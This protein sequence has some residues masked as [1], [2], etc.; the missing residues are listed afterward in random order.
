[1]KYPNGEEKSY[2]VS[3]I[4][5]IDDPGKVINAALKSL[6]QGVTAEEIEEE[7]SRLCY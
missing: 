6:K 2:E 3:S 1:M 5:W 7:R 4:D